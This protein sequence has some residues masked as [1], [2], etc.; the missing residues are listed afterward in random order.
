MQS[1]QL[2]LLSILLVASIHVGGLAAAL[3]SSSDTHHPDATPPAI[4]GVLVMLE[5]EPAPR[6]VAQPPITPTVAPIPPVKKH[7]IPKP[8][9]KQAPPS[10][11][12][13]ETQEPETK[14]A[15][16][17]QQSAPLPKEEPLSLAPPREVAGQ[18]SN[19]APPY[20]SMSRRLR[21]E[22]T[23]ILEILILADG[24]VSEVRLK[25]SS[26]YKRL[27]DA[28][29]KAIAK[30]HYVPATRAGKAVDFWYEQPVEFTLH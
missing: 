5:P 13:I 20:P 10:E 18:H 3:M 6:V 15:D 28:A 22:G 12:A 27:D 25:V 14:P 23:V 19:A 24:S 16:V 4:Q 7:T 2:S 21:E 8:V 11:R 30:W 1:K 17:I 26:G 29:K 9:I